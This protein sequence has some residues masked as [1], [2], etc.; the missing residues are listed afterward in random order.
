MKSPP[1]CEGNEEFGTEYQNESH[2]VQGDTLYNLI[3]HN[4]Q[5]AL[6]NE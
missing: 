5:S 3:H 2:E 6:R 1:M 4:E